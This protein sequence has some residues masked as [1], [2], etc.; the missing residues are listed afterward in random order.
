M[1][2][3][4]DL[5]EWVRQRA[6]IQF[7]AI[8]LP[9]AALVVVDMQRIFVR[10]GEIFAMPRSEEIISRINTLAKAVRAGGGMVVFTRHTVTDEAPYA[11]PSWVMADPKQF[12]I[13][14]RLRADSPGHELDER[15]DFRDGDLV[16]N[17]H[18]YSAFTYNSSTLA[19]DLTA[20]GV[21]TV[22]VVGVAT[23]ACCETTTRDASQLGYR[24]FFISDATAALTDIEHNYALLT[25]AA[26]FADV[27]NTESML[28]LC[29]KRSA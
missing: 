2:G 1:P 21:D 29:Q 4:T 23:N 11:M 20:R 9:T 18:R 27:R 16:I 22:I 6:L 7:T 12:A 28:Q 3:T 10:A 25:I 26:V 13:W 17:K 24:T 5:P 19:A 14:D 15:M 8:H